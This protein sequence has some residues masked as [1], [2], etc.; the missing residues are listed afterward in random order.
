MGHTWWYRSIVSAC[1]S[2]ERMTR[3]MKTHMTRVMK[4]HMTRVMKST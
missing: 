4:T 3:V 1:V 2:S